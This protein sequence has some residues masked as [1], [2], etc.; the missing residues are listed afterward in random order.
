MQKRTRRSKKRRQQAKKQRKMFIVG[1]LIVLG[2][3]LLAGTGYLVLSSRVN[4]TAQHVVYDNVYVDSVD[5]S[6]MEKTEVKQALEKQAETYR[7]Q[8]IVLQ[9]ADNNVSVSLGELGFSIKDVEKRAEDAVSYGKKGNIFGRYRKVR[10][11]DDEK[12]VIPVSYAIDKEKAKAVFAEK[13]QPL[14]HP[15]QDASIS[16]ENGAFVITDEIAGQT[17]DV[18]ASIKAVEEYLTKSWKGKDAAVTLV[19]ISDEPKVKRKD[20]EPIQNLLGTFTTYCGS[21]GGRVQNI[22]SGT[23][24][25]NGAIVMPQEEYSANAAMEPYTVENGFTEAGSY[26]S[27][28]VVQSMGGGICQVSSTLYN[29][30]ILAELEITQRQPHSMLVNYVEP[31]MDAAIAGTT[32]DLKFKNN[33]DT[34]IYIEGY[35]SGGNL[36]F[37]IYGK[38]TRSA[39]RTIEFISETL[40]SREPAKS[41]VE[42]G[43][44]LG[45]MQ[46]SGSAHVGKNARLWKVVYENGQEVSR[47]IFNNSS[48]NA[49]PV[50]VS[51]GT[52]SSNA[53]ASAMVRSAIA[54]QDEGK[55]QAAIAAAQA[56]IQE[57]AAQ[58]AAEEAAAQQQQQEQQPPQEQPPQEQIPQPP[59]IDNAQAAP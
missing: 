45:T 6:G 49:S 51:V 18:D 15:S 8:P 37:N 56:K 7:N 3:L 47:E 44:A 40:S 58:K 12:K 26:E 57:A 25:I 48:Y 32:K 35:V 10:R 52:A 43:A 14:E 55:I 16:R 27:G 9:V 13:A 28:K 22:V 59:S 50:T 23:G 21:G 46:R 38:E 54:T 4:K 11:L 20:L 1:G 53:E 36:T 29:A 5:V 33:T 41:F 24:H 17:I 31:S 30:A 2:C 34:P 42:S 39:E 19:S